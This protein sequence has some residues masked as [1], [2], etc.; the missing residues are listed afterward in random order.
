M[1][2]PPAKM[3]RASLGNA[4]KAALNNPNV[5]ARFALL[6]AR[7]RDDLRADREAREQDE[8]REAAQAQG[9]SE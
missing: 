3:S 5:V 6:D 7:M 2:K 9:D 1:T 4:A 8:A